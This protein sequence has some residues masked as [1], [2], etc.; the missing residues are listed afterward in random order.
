MPDAP[1]GFAT[2]SYGLDQ[3]AVRWFDVVPND[4]NALTVYPRCLYVG[5]AGDVAVANRFGDSSII[6][7]VPAGSFLP[8]RP[9]KVLFTGT[10]ATNLVAL[11]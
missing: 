3:P 5:G 10:S 11:Y 4:T 6:K 2:Y 9:D 1:N 8:V 7:N